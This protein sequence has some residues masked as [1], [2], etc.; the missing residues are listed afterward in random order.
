MFGLAEI[1]TLHIVRRIVWR[2][3]GTGSTMRRGN[4]SGSRKRSRLKSN[5]CPEGFFCEIG[6][7]LNSKLVNFRS[8]L[9]VRR[10]VK[11]VLCLC[12][13]Q[14]PLI[15]PF[16]SRCEAFFYCS[17]VSLKRSRHSEGHE[18]VLRTFAVVNE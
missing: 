7:R 2:C 12:R 4:K 6:D 5:S 18:Y 11:A 14:G 13:D 1:G 8:A 17:I 15:D 9:A 16:L 10:E 3:A